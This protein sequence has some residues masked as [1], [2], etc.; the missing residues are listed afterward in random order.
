MP[1]LR[2]QDDR[3]IETNEVNFLAT[4][5][6]ARCNETGLRVR[7]LP[8]GCQLV[9]DVKLR[10]LRDSNVRLITFGNLVVLAHFDM[11]K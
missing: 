5:P 7:L 3:L 9:V 8:D 2:S 6:G 1:P 4:R 10:V 11:D